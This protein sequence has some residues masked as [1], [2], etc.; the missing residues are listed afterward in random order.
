[1]SFYDK[2]ACCNVISNNFFPN[3]LQPRITLQNL[4]E[5]DLFKKSQK[6]KQFN[7]S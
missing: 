5:T 6:K 2:R 4:K 3:A 7:L 1:M